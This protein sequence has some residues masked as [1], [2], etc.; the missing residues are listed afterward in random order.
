MMHLPVPDADTSNPFQTPRPRG[1]RLT[2]GV[3]RVVVALQCFGMA[4]AHLQHQQPD[5]FCELICRSRDLPGDQIANIADIVAYALVVCGVITLLRPATLILLPVIVY[6]AGTAVAPLVQS[7]TSATQL[8]AAA[9]ATQIITPLALML[10][11]FWPPRIK[12]SLAMCLAATALLKLATAASFI[13]QGVIC[14]DQSRRGGAAVELLHAAILQG[15][16][17]NFPAV[18]VPPILAALGVIQI[19]LAMAL[20]SGRSRMVLAGCVIFGI[21][22]AL[23]HTIADSPTGYSQ[24]LI[25]ISLAGAPLAVLMFHCTSIREQSPVYL[26]EIKSL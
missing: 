18:D 14:M 7:N 10:V 24:T 17:S 8:A 20:L 16:R 1:I 2:Q 11:D 22:M 13:A 12:P 3:L 19:G 26:P 6:F 5:L 25:R 15:I 21:L 4:A 9:Q 23:M